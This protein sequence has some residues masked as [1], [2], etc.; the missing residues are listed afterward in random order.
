MYFDFPVISLIFFL[1]T[2]LGI[3]LA[4]VT[5]RRRPNPGSLPLTIFILAVTLWVF[6]YGFEMG[7]LTVADRILW[8]KFEYCGIVLT[9]Y[10][11]V[12][13]T[14]DYTRKLIW[15]TPWFLIVLGLIPLATLI[16][17]WTNGS[18]G[19]VW[20]QVYQITGVEGFQVKWE[21]GFGFWVMLVYQYV[22]FGVGLLVLAMSMKNRSVVYRRQIWILLIGTLIPIAGN[23]IYAV[24]N[25]APWF[26]NIIPLIFL[27]SGIFYVTTINF[28]R[29]L[30]IVP[31]AQGALVESLPDGI[32]VTDI[33]NLVMDINP[34]G[35]KMAGLKRHEQLGK[36]L[37]NLWQEL[38]IVIKQVKEEDH[39]ELESEKSG[40]KLSLD[41]SLNRLRDKKQASAGYLIVLRDFTYRRQMENNLRE[42]EARYATL[43]EQSNEGVLI[44]QNG[45]Y[46]FANHTMAEMSG[47]RVEEIVGKPLPYLVAETYKETIVE[48][49]K[50]RQAGES[51]P[52]TYEIQV[53][54]KNG[55][56]LD[57]E[58][59]VGTISYEGKRASIVTVRDITE[60]KQTQKKLEELYNGEK[61][62]RGNLQ[63]EIEKRSKYTRALVHE[64]NTPLTSIL[65]S[66]ELLEAEVSDETLT[67]LVK[68]VRRASFNLKQRIDELIELA[69]GE[70]G[71]LKV[72]VMPVA[73]GK[74]VEE[75]VSEMKP[76]AVNKKLQMEVEIGGGVGLVLGD[77]GRLRQ[78]MSNLLSN[79]IKFSERGRIDIKVAEKG[80]EVEVAVKD[81]GRG[82]SAEQLENLFDPYRRKVNEGQELGGLGIG[83]ALSKM[84][85]ELHKGT[86]K[87]ESQLGEGA[88]FTFTV[89]KYKE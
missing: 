23:I 9:G 24:F 25:F 26:T 45:E 77:R 68:N 66:G 30:D 21:H 2:L 75:I 15:K 34:A 47:Y 14:L 8:A 83:L 55:E 56:I 46:V 72:N 61:I 89:P 78:V 59:S 31:V 13:F 17:V 87:V 54:K 12:C 44:L 35:E 38:A 64:L 29:F 60:R 79:A 11:W 53:V 52:D 43:V 22:A 33:D 27:F 1:G 19:W 5:Y 18:H 16:L 36:P 67:A 20:S 69:R 6:A 73:I 62:L 49:N 81:S 39:V 37:E 41:I 88:T 57:V 63:D 42:S 74:L 65:A 85:V 58:I 84:F 4:C 48:R 40:A 7:A 50:Q 51:V 71:M 80:E 82:M 28:Y 10:M 32:I 3:Y 86:I 76:L 70:V